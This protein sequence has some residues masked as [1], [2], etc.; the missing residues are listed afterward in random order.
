MA[1]IKCNFYQFLNCFLHRLLT[2]PCPVMTEQ[3]LASD[4]RVYH[5]LCFEVG[6]QIDRS[7]SSPHLPA[8]KGCCCYIWWSD[9]IPYTAGS[10][11]ARGRER[12][13]GKRVG[14]TGMNSGV[15]ISLFLPEEW[16]MFPTLIMTTC[17]LSGFI[18]T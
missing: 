16:E 3:L 17:V 12:R 4:M 9:P 7:G 11:I 14:G 1:M 13:P 6:R 5:A 2:E 8:S 18:T 15:V 10:R